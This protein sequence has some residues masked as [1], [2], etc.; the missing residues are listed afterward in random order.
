MKT[1]KCSS[2]LLFDK[3]IAAI[4][5]VLMTGNCARADYQ[6]VIL[7]DHPLAYYPLNL[8]ADTNTDASGYYI[9]SDLS[10]N[11]N[12]GVYI[13][14]Y[15]GYNNVSGPSSYITNGVSFDGLTTYVDLGAGSNTALLN[16]SGPITM[17]AW[18]QPSSPTVGAS[19][20]ADIIG[21]GYDSS[22]NDDELVMR[23]NGGYYYGG[24]Y[25]SINNGAS[26]HGGVQ[27]TNWTYVVSTYD[28][29]NWNLYVNGVLVGTG[30]DT[31]GAINFSDPWQ[32]G[33][34]SA[35]GTS[36]LFQGNISQ[37]ALYNYG[38]SPG[39][40]FDHYFVGKYGIA[41]SNSIPIITKQPVS[42]VSYIGG[43][44]TFSVSVL[45]ALP[46]TNQWYK[47]DSP[48]AGQ[49]NAML[50]ISNINSGD[51]ADYSVVVGNS[52]GITNST[53]A[54]LSLQSLGIYQS[55]IISDHPLAYYPLDPNLDTSSTATDLSGHGNNATYYNTSPGFNDVAGPT[56]YIT[57][58]ANFNGS[59]YADMG[60]SSLLNFGGQIT[61]E[62]WVQPSN[63]SKN[64]QDIIAK[65]Y[66]S[67]QNYA[68]IVLRQD[69]A[70]YT[71]NGGSGGVAQVGQWAYVVSTY[72]GTNWNL[73]VNGVLV[74]QSPSGSG[75]ADFSDPWR[76]GSGSADGANRLF[77]GNLSQVALYNYGLTP[78][79]V[80][81]HY[82]VGT[83][84]TSPSN[85]IPIISTQPAAQSAYLG[86]T[87]HF[88]VQA[89][90][91]L[92]IT[93][94]W[95]RNNQPIPGQTN[96]TLTIS[97]ID[98]GDVANYSVVIGNS[99]GTT[100]SI[101]VAL[102]L[103]TP[104]NSLLWGTNQ[105]NGIWD[106]GNSANW[107]NLSNGQQVTFNTNDEA[108]FSD[109]AGEP[110]TVS[111]S[112]TV[113]P[114]VITINSDTNNF[115]F[116]GSGNI[117]G[118][119]SLIK[120][121]SSTATIDT[122]SSLSGPVIISGG[123][124]Y[125]G[126]NSFKSVSSI[127]ITNDSTLD[128]GGGTYDNNQPVTVS[129][130]GT[131]GQ[132]AIV[133]SY[134]DY[135]G[136]TFDITLADNTT[137]GG[138]NRWDLD[139]GSISGP[140][141]LTLSISNAD[142]NYME[143]NSVSVGA[144]V[145]GITLSSGTLGVKNMS[146]G[147]QNPGTV[148]TIGTNAQML[149]YNGSWNGSIHIMGGGQLNTAPAPANFTGDNITFENN[150]QFVSYS[151]P[152]NQTIDSTIT[153]NGIALLSIGDH[154]ITY[155]NIISG[156]GGMLVEQW[157][158][159]MIFPAA[160]TYSGPTIIANGPQVALTGNGSLSD[161]SLVFFGGTDPNAIHLDAS[162]RS[163]HTFTLSS[164]QTLSGI[165]A[166]A[167]NLTVDSGAILSP[168][169]T[170]TTLGITVGANSIGAISA[171]NNIILNGTTIIKLDGS[172]TNDMIQAGG[173]IAYGGTLNLSNISGSSLVAGDFF[174]IFNATSYTGSFAITPS[175]PG[176]GLAWDLSQLDTGK[177]S[178]IP[179]GASG[180]VVSSTKIINGNLVLTGSG[181]TTSG[182]YYVITTTNLATPLS[183]WTVLST[184]QYDA[185][186]AFNVTNAIN[187][188]MPQQFYR[189]KQ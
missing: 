13:N 103:L 154:N 160:N 128:L 164:G 186:G 110:A 66:D 55:A 1:P 63:V 27:T 94:Q 177:I 119:G 59:T 143:M 159:Q 138:H 70:T 71:G 146:S 39:Q 121:G 80:F 31:V 96:A 37:V 162:G 42:Q 11:D 113:S 136:E 185:N 69:S 12:N 106:T 126:N 98:N 161:S 74:K 43:S 91:V 54:N 174:Q 139:G 48:L 153:L 129:G 62:A 64:L 173:S 2:S 145:S 101:S 83:Y 87:V 188:G 133:N 23:A 57:N 18:V 25:N 92:P 167:G 35:D 166:V 22:Q 183:N 99:N 58:A 79:Q 61:L 130:S 45:S 34:G 17:E 137:F 81:A 29:T 26:A 112:G 104:G 165:G 47:N 158:H 60:D 44:A 51:V 115:L 56:A 30:A 116:N 93:N 82:F 72:D 16:F 176:A 24:T 120:K 28:G 132:G 142:N 68:E 88:T 14:I 187:S 21:K 65:G 125:A 102:S 151:F 127:T 76:I 155:N 40:V 6:S 107:V 8:S 46:T 131:N 117:T 189:I 144:D 4:A 152:S 52:N 157:N 179:S 97:D 180:P 149:F 123:S 175:T 114:S 78:N 20:P 15:P 105:N 182:S 53:P 86:G 147:F 19:T 89:L 100:N 41:P 141:Q 111:V 32:I 9:A 50:T 90:S 172:G 140:Y 109:A 150:A 171:T 135:P 168:A 124:I 77:T 7:S 85:A 181:G 134:D 169:G 95:Y 84:G 118:P 170:N 38:L 163:D 148:V 73:Y 67:S 108:L 5:L 122:S 10:G 156:S 75:A 3:T 178:V 33:R 49:T 184:N 36:R